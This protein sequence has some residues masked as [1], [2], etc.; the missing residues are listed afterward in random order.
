[1]V[2]EVAFITQ[3]PLSFLNYTDELRNHSYWYDFH[4]SYLDGLTNESTDNEGFT[5]VLG[6][7]HRARNPEHMRVL[8]LSTADSDDEAAPVCP[9]RQP[10]KCT[11]VK[12]SS[13]NTANSFESLDIKDI[14]DPDDTNYKTYEELPDLCSGS[15]SESN[16]AETNGSD[17]E[18]I[19]NTEVSFLFQMW[20]DTNTSLYS[21]H[22]L[23]PPKLFHSVTRQITIPAP[24]Q[25]PNER[26]PTSRQLQL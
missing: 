18:E 25:T 11:K 8:A 21:S 16:S 4:P 20:H 17:I 3:P 15:D 7:G 13:L 2:G 22:N 10:S 1:V 23:F 9:R 19:T 5:P 6:R 12:S 24:R 26:R 14:S